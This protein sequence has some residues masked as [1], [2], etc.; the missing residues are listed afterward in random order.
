[1]SRA[2]VLDALRADVALGQMLVPSNILTN[3]SKEGPP[4]HLAPGPFAVIRW[5]GKTIDPAVNRGPRDVNIWVHI[6][7]RQSTD[8]TRIDRILK[9]TKEIMLSLEDVA[10]ADGAHLVSTRFLA[11]SDDLVDPGFETIT[12][13]AT[14]SVLSRST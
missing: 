6:P 3:Y 4:N 9:R 14:F 10:G 13:Y 2:A 11:E 1:M 5:G 7:Q 8:Y 12:R